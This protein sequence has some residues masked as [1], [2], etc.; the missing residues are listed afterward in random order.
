MPPPPFTEEQKEILR[1]QMRGYREVN[2][3]TLR[4]ARMATTE[5]RWVSFRLLLDRAASHGISHPRPDPS[6]S[7]VWSE[8]KK[9]Y[10]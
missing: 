1:Q 5:A 7:S 8:L 10:G 3:I 4:E 9:R 6:G 2:A